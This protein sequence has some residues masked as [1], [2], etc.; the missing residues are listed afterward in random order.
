[1]MENIVVV[2]YFCPLTVYII[3][4]YTTC[5]ANLRRIVL[6]RF[7]FRRKRFGTKNVRFKKKQNLRLFMTV[8]SLDNVKIKFYN[9]KFIYKV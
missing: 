3:N 4:P 2:E 5:A 1:M 9:I 8:R 6:E 7:C